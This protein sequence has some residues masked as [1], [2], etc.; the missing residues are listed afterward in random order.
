M[1]S[2]VNLVICALVL[3]SAAA[4]GGGLQATSHEMPRPSADAATASNW[5]TISRPEDSFAAAFPSDVRVEE[6]AFSDGQFTRTYATDPDKPARFAVSVMH[7][8]HEPSAL[9]CIVTNDRIQ[10]GLASIEGA[11]VNLTQSVHVDGA[12]VDADEIHATIDNNGRHSILVTRVIWQR[13]K[14]IQ[15]AARV[16]VPPGQQGMPPQLARF[17]DSFRVI[18]PSA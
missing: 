12:D 13:D 1:K 9:E 6:S 11:T 5:R 14:L 10:A 17:I 7:L 16:E 3:C 18:E 15:I 2:L 4:C 8:G